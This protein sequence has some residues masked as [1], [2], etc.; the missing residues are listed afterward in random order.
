[1]VTRDNLRIMW[2]DEEPLEDFQKRM[3]VLVQ[4]RGKVKSYE[5]KR[6][7]EGWMYIEWT[8]YN[9]AWYEEFKPKSKLATV[10]YESLRSEE[11]RFVFDDHSRLWK[12]KELVPSVREVCR[13]LNPRMQRFL[14]AYNGKHLLLDRMADRDTEMPD[15]YMDS[16]DVSWFFKRPK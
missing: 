2:K 15:W 12:P 11:G 10:I 6:F 14:H 8:T 3:E 13:Q 9:P 7:E 4:E 1:M 16:G 5:K